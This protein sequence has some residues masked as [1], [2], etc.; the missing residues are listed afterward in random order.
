M[1][2]QRVNYGSR[3]VKTSRK[4]G[5]RRTKRAIF[6]SVR[7]HMLSIANGVERR[8]FK[9]QRSSIRMGR[10]GRLVIQWAGEKPGG[11][12]VAQPLRK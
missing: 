7:D 9:C 8:F 1:V 5:G 11:V 10:G 12:D 2:R 4:G 6:S 3:R